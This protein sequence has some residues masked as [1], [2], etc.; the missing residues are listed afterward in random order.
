[1]PRARAREPIPPSP[2]MTTRLERVEE[3]L[4]RGTRTMKLVAIVSEEH[5]CCADTVLNDVAQVRNRWALES[6]ADRP[7][8]R[9]EML[10]QVEDLYG[11]CVEAGDRKAAVAAL[12]LKA[13]L[14][15][16]R[17]RPMAALV[18]PKAKP[19]DIATW[20]AGELGF[21]AP[22]TSE[23]DDAPTFPAPGG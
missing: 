18:D 20:L 8:K 16:A 13:D 23:A 1:M 17:V 12:T 14:H 10:A 7:A 15:G 3:L 22:T 5:D 9:A 21:A 2:R 11:Q 19:A 6:A 4:T